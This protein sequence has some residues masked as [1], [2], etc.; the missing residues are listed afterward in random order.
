MLEGFARPP[1]TMIALL[2]LLYF[3]ANFFLVFRFK[4]IRDTNREDDNITTKA[5]APP[6]DSVTEIKNVYTTMVYFA[7]TTINTVGYGDVI[8]VNEYEYIV[9]LAFLL[10][11]VFLYGYIMN[12]IQSIAKADLD[13][14]NM[15][16]EHIEAF[17]TWLV[18]LEN[19]KAQISDSETTRNNQNRAAPLASHVVHQAQKAFN[20]TLRYDRVGIFHN[21]FFGQ[22]SFNTKSALT[23]LYF[24]RFKTEFPGIYSLLC[25]MLTEEFVLRL[26]VR[27]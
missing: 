26:Q 13:V 9:A 10:S 16:R 15:R 4:I 3:F 22:L 1:K 12:E 7:V 21:T 6:P 19:K 17:G 25:E 24:D 5:K 23:K 11:G 20:L 2:T 14:V 27:V 18:T 8:P